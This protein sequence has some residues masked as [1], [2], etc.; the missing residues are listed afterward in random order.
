MPTSSWFIIAS[1]PSLTIEDVAILKGQRVLCI[2][3]NYLRAPW[4]DVLYACDGIWWD[5]HHHREELKAFK[6]RKITQDKESADKYRL[7]YIKG[8][9]ALGLS[10]DP[11]CIHLGANSGIQAI[12]LAS[13]LRHAGHRRQVS[14]VRRACLARRRPGSRSLAPLAVAL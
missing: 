13:W 3:D 9:D 11:A 5:R 12:N 10:R 14:L 7:E 2:N 6:G 1:G 8:V 4:A